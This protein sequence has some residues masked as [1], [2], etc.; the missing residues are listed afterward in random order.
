MN[1]NSPT[2][3]PGEQLTY[4][5]SVNNSG[6]AAS[7][8]T[9]LTGMLDAGATL[10]S[11]QLVSRR[12][13]IACSPAER[14]RVQSGTVELADTA[15]GTIVVAVSDNASADIRFTAIAGAD[16]LDRTPADNDDSI[17][18]ELVAAPRQ[19]TNLQASGASAHIDVDWSTPGDNGSAITR[20]EL[21]RKTDTGEFTPVSP[22]PPPGATSYRD[23]E[24]EE[25]IE[26][27]YRLRAVNMDGEAGWS[28]EPAASLRIA[29][30]PVT[31]GGG[32]GGGFGPAPVAPKFDDGFRQH[33]LSPS[34]R[35]SAMRLANLWQPYIQMTSKSLI[36]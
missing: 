7:T 10:V 24:V 2:V 34:T 36:P 19:I 30:P 27:A 20:Y 17:T 29:P 21:E 32:G 1:A 33:G 26:Y 35:G 31:G 28:N 18:T 4:N 5:W 15:S 6:P 3:E 14:S 25:D 23:V 9:V 12:P 11:T 22:Q 16:Q 13:A 8:S